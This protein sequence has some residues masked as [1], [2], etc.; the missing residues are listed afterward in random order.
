MADHDAFGIHRHD[1]RG[2]TAQHGIRTAT[3]IGHP[4]QYFDLPARAQAHDHRRLTRADV[5]HTQGYPPAAPRRRRGMPVRLAFERIEHLHGARAMHAFA[6][7]ARLAIS[8]SV[9]SP[10]V[11]RIDTQRLGNHVDVAFAGE[12]RLW[13]TWRAHG[14][15]RNA[16]GVDRLDFK[17]GHGHVVRGQCVVRRHHQ[18]G[19]D[20]ACRVC[21]AVDQHLRLVGQE[22]ALGA[23]RRT[24]FQD[25]RVA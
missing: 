15:A 18:V 17:P 9:V 6:R 13:I 4:S 20:F 25:G 24:Q 23:D 2:H 10:Q 11:D 5:A 19:R 16:V 21:P 1:R 12:H 7:Y 22:H 14:A 3:L 8:Q